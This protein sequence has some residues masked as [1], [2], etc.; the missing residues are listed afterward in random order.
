MEEVNGIFE[1]FK[2]RKL[3][4]MQRLL[5][6]LCGL[7]PI[8]LSAQTPFADPDSILVQGEARPR[9]LL[10][11]TFHFN[12]PGLD[13]HKVDTSQQVDIL[14]P[15][16]QKEVEELVDYLMQFQ[17]TKIVVEAGENT[18]YLMRKYERWQAGAEP[19]GRNEIYQLGFRLLERTGLDTLYGC[20]ATSI[21]YDMKRHADSSAFVPYLMDVFDGYDF[22][23]SDPITH[24]YSQWYDYQNHLELKH[25]LLESFLYNNSRKVLERGYGAYLVG[26]FRTEDHRGADALALYWYNRNL[27]TYSKIQSLDIQSD[28]RILV[29]F[30]AGHVSILDHL[31]RASPEFKLVPF[32]SLGTIDR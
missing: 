10:V 1:V 9:V 22:Q 30:G 27:R 20:D 28:D 18:G 32:G 21:P 12:Y 23:S 14:S 4:I 24:R 17:P 13:A 31:F 8:W 29:L 26:D 16:R 7:F 15:R 2:E 25:T 3:Q 5:L 19:L 6:V 11:G